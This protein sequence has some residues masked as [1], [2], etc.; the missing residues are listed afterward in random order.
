MFSYFPEISVSKYLQLPYELQTVER[1]WCAV[2]T[3]RFP[4][5]DKNRG[6]VGYSEM[7]K[8][9]KT[10]QTYR[11]LPTLT[12]PTLCPINELV[13]PG[14]GSWLLLAFFFY[15]KKIKGS[16]FLY[17]RL[18]VGTKQRSSVEYYHVGPHLEVELRCSRWTS[19]LGPQIQSYCLNESI[20]RGERYRNFALTGPCL[21]L[22]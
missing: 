21:Q 15:K 19:W 9:L 22:W 20:Q 18:R 6:N 2:W 7:W 5:P 3:D 10:P 16:C 14:E 11:H 17:R 12:K 4:A 13:V 1:W 8:A